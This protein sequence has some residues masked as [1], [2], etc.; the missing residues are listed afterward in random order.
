M[1]SAMGGGGP[2]PHRYGDFVD[3][4]AAIVGRAPLAGLHTTEGRLGDVLIDITDLPA[5]ATSRDSF[6]PLLGHLVGQW[7][8]S[9]IPVV[10]GVP[11]ATED[12]L[13]AFGAAT[14]STGAVAL[15]HMVGVTPEAHTLADAFGGRPPQQTVNVTLADLRRAWTELSTRREGTLGAVCIGTPHFSIA[16]FHQLAALLDGRQIH[17]STPLYVNAGRWVYENATAQ[18]VTPTLLTA[19]VQIVTDTCTYNTP[20][21]GPVDGLVMTNSAKWAWYAPRNIGVD[22]L[23]ADLQ[24]CVESAIEGKIS[25]HA[26][27]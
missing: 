25:V 10:V 26:G 1:L 15:F 9:R 3:I 4:A 21:L 18:G 19:G 12:Q 16:E 8:G 14:A 5:S 17:P 20:I 11:G 7:C 13:K 24:D 6:F 27:Y 23:F 2:P 22:V